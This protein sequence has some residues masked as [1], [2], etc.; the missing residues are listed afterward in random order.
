[1]KTILPLLLLVGFAFALEPQG[2]LGGPYRVLE[3]TDGDTVVLESFD[4]VRLIGI[5]TPEKYDGQRLNKQAAE[6]GLTEEEIQAMGEQASSITTNLLAG[7][8][9]YVELDIEELDRYGRILAYLYLEDSGGDWTYQ[10]KTYKQVNLEIMRSG[11]A[12][13]L[14]ITPNVAY[15]EL[16]REAGS[17]A[18]NA[19]I[20]MWATPE[21]VQ[22]PTTAPMQAGGG[23]GSVTVKCILFNPDGQDDGRE[24]VTLQA[25]QDVDLT[26]WWI[27]DLKDHRFYLQGVLSAGQTLE[28]LNPAEPVWNNDGDTVFVYNAQTQLI[29]QFA[30]G[31]DGPRAC[32]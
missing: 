29:D 19:G 3:I 25:N 32:R 4:E 28:V 8:S 9:V 5:D 7:Q 18:R 10:G 31:G 27:V 23:S 30:Y 22:E 20:G 24:T 13:P 6:H 15:A 17:T 2:Q 11:W 1:V 26:G 21:M 14:T 12:E 16:Y